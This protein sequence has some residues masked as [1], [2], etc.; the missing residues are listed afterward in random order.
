MKRDHGTPSKIIAALL[1][2]TA[3]L[4]GEAMKDSL[5]EKLETY[6]AEKNDVYQSRLLKYVERL[7]KEHIDHTF[8]RSVTPD[9]IE[10]MA[11]QFSHWVEGAQEVDPDHEGYKAI[12]ELWYR[13]LESITKGSYVEED[14]L[15]TLK[16]LRE[17]EALLLLDLRDQGVIYN[18]VKKINNDKKLYDHMS[19]IELTRFDLV[20]SPNY[21]SIFKTNMDRWGKLFAHII[22]FF[23]LG[24]VIDNMFVKVGA[25][26]EW[27]IWP[28]YLP[29]LL[30]GV[31]G[32]IIQTRNRM[33]ELTDK[34]ND[35]V[36]FAPKK[37]RTTKDEEHDDSGW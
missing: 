3:A 28:Y 2:P 16:K 10:I 14:L 30:I 5:K 13:I 24:I 25:N 8:N 12:S 21:F 9:D 26:W 35:L 27:G 37:Q 36:A 23:V 33:W 31:V 15:I 4:I 6:R 17:N 1:H 29:L 32:S 34:G 20:Q 7:S 18:D 19:F 11:I 22:V